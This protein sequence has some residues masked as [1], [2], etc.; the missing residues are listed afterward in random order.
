MSGE[1]AAL[2]SGPGTPVSMS[3]QKLRERLMLN[4]SPISSPVVSG[5]VVMQ[6]RQ[7]TTLLDYIE[8]LQRYR[9]GRRALHLHLSLL[10]PHNRIRSRIRI[11]TNMFE[12]LLKK[13]VGQLLTLES[14]DIILILKE[15]NF[16][17]MNASVT[18][19][20]ELFAGDPLIRPSS[21]GSDSLCSW[22]SLATE[23]DTLLE[24]C[25]GFAE[26]KPGD[27]HD[28]PEADPGLDPR[29]LATLQA[30]LE[31]LDLSSFLRPRQIC[32]VN[33]GQPAKLAFL[34]FH[35]SVDA[36]ISRLWPDVD[37]LAN[38]W[39][40][41]YLNELLEHRMFE[42]LPGCGFLPDTGAYGV[43]LNTA[44]VL[45]EE[46]MALDAHLRRNEKQTVMI[47]L[48]LIDVYSDLSTYQFARDFARQRGYHVC[49][50]GLTHENI[51]LIDRQ[52]LGVELVMIDWQS[53]METQLRGKPGRALREAI[54]RCE[55]ER[56]ILCHCES[57]RAI[58]VGWSMG[59]T[60]F[61]GPY[62]DSMLASSTILRLPQKVA[63]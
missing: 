63:S 46:F 39:L 25:R 52:R 18:K 10:Q 60:M 59:V 44:S 16:E 43:H 51:H 23:Y 47:V 49:L 32:A 35:L 48:H 30:R 29:E 9:E 54:K 26:R 61:E 28:M 14:G 27:E 34:E 15:A 55:K 58:E 45:S 38:R 53:N 37:P 1:P 8:R 22:Y 4:T 5:S 20:R 62:I 56:A 41:L 33:P 7:E 11:A 12:T 40:F 13:F 19:V 31:T 50:D 36:L 21:D 17:E 42:L 57:K 2:F 6:S 24:L 3:W